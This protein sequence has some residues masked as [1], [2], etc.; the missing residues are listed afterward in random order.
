MFST[1]SP[2]SPLAHYTSSEAL[3]TKRDFYDIQLKKLSY[4]Y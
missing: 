3:Q 1:P 2:A 4:D